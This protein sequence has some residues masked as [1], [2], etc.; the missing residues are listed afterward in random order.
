MLSRRRRQSANVSGGAGWDEDQCCSALTVGPDG[1]PIGL[2]PT[3]SDWL[4]A[5]P[6]GL[7]KLLGWVE[8]RYPGAPIWV[9]ENGVVDPNPDT[10]TGPASQASQGPK[11]D[12]FRVQYHRD[13]LNAVKGAI[14]DGVVVRGYFI[15]SLLDNVEWGDGLR[16]RFGL[17]EVAR[18]SL[19]RLA[20]AIVV[21]LTQF[22]E[23]W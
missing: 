11:N 3:G 6:W 17:F 8:Q 13:Y 5:V 22:I 9:T 18:P 2:R 23:E 20:K 4:Y 14:G 15:W 12:S 16:D 21:W 1:R 10:E 7:R 19:T